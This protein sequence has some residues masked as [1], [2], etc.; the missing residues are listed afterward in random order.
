[1]YELRYEMVCKPFII[2]YGGM[3]YRGEGRGLETDQHLRHRN[4]H[5]VPPAAPI[6]AL[7]STWN[8]E[9][10]DQH[11][12]SSGP[13]KFHVEHCPSHVPNRAKVQNETHPAP[14]IK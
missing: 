1:M 5:F 8:I 10:L 11:S 2:K 13:Q 14:D 12:I 7:C 4:K 3:A 9:D 6:Q